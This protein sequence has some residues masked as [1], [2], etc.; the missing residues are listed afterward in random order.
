MQVILQQSIQHILPGLVSYLQEVFPLPTPR[1]HLC[2]L[3]T[4][5]N[6]YQ[7]C[8]KQ[9]I[10]VSC[11]GTVLFKSYFKREWW[12][13]FAGSG[14]FFLFHFSSLF[15]QQVLYD[16]LSRADTAQDYGVRS[17]HRGEGGGEVV[18]ALRAVVA[19][20]ILT[21][22]QRFLE[23]T[24]KQDLILFVCLFLLI[25]G[26]PRSEKKKS[27]HQAA[28]PLFSSLPVAS[29][30]YYQLHCLQILGFSLISE[31]SH[32]SSLPRMDIY[33]ETC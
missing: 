4:H 15:G 19:D 10:S 30:S 22:P 27:P 33:M 5:S 2:T 32:F 18:A 20:H 8:E 31:C 12:V 21:T 7:D 23:S 3:H 9:K 1:T 26:G 17:H 13:F 24:H 11:Q 6:S 29:V 16:T 25:V 14:F 28:M